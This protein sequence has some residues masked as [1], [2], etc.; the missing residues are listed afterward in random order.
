LKSVGEAGRGPEE[1]KAACCATR[2]AQLR[3]ARALR[4]SEERQRATQIPFNFNVTEANRERRI[5]VKV[6]R[7]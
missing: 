5:K 2:S 1:K 3:V 4:R 7:D 6:E